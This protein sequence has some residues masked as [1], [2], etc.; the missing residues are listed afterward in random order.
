MITCCR[1]F[2]FSLKC[3]TSGQISLTKALLRGQ[4]FQEN[5]Y[6]FVKTVVNVLISL[7]SALFSTVLKLFI[8]QNLNTEL[9]SLR[10]APSVSI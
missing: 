4:K 3:S 8:F 2:V 7:Y 6:L 1:F 9:H 5:L 10:V